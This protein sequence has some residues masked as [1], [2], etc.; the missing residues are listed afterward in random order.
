MNA[1]KHRLE[2]LSKHI[3]DYLVGS[4]QDSNSQ[5][6]DF[7]SDKGI[8][9][10]EFSKWSSGKYDFNLYEIA[11]LELALHTTFINLKGYFDGEDIA[12]HIKE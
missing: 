2:K 8:T 5:I 6:D 10:E 11:R 9:R 3:A 7:C 4:L 1:P 12:D